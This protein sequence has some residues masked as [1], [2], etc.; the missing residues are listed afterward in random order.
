[1]KARGRGIDHRVAEVQSRSRS[2]D[3]QRTLEVGTH[4]NITVPTPVVGRE[5]IY[6][7]DGYS[8]PGPRPIY[9][10]RAGGTGDLTLDDRKESNASI[11]WSHARGGP[12]VPTPILYGDHLYV[13]NNIGILT[14]Y[15]AASGKQV[16]EKRMAGSYSASPIA[17]GGKLYFTSEEGDVRVIKAGPDYELLAT[18]PIGEPCL[19]TPAVADGILVIRSL[20]AVLAIGT[21]IDDAAKRGGG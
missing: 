14:C 6:L 8:R 1:M 20:S 5:L 10:V 9:A 12:Y 7:A 2:A 3:R 21:P 19:A 18:N 15:D 17:A 13:G 4:S 16:Y 11:A